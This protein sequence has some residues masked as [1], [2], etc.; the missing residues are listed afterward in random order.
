MASH[1][2]Y[3]FM[4]KK[5]LFHLLSSF[6]YF[7]IYHTSSNMRRCQRLE[8]NKQLS[9]LSQCA[10]A[11]ANM[12]VVFSTYRDISQRHATS[13]IILHAFMMSKYFIKIIFVLVPMPML[14]VKIIPYDVGRSR[15][16]GNVW[17]LCKNAV[18]M[19]FIAKP[20]F[21][22]KKFCTHWRN[23]HP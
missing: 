22:S 10:F 19:E 4:I 15:T 3:S 13:N 23:F 9:S 12:N 20:F 14:H 21:P 1:T 6:F 18:E 17:I 2:F 5:N 7:S 8:N 16:H 11:F